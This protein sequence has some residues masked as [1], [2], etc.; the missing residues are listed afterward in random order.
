MLGLAA[1]L[2]ASTCASSEDLAKLHDELTQLSQQF[3]QQQLEVSLLREEDKKI[4][5]NIRC[6]DSQ[7]ADFMTEADHC[8]SGQCPQRNLDRVLGFMATQKHVLIRLRP[9]QTAADMAPL[10]VTQL[11]DMLEP[12]Q[13]TGVSRMLM[14]TM[15]LNMGYE[16]SADLAEKRADAL[17]M[18]M[19][20]A[21][22]LAPSVPRVGPFPVTCQNKSQLLDGYARRFP[23]DRPVAGEP[24]SKE[25]QVAIWIFKV[26]C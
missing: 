8:Q 19:R 22:Q 26:D 23:A 15:Q 9:N 4:W 5:R 13:L 17:L 20:R 10:R 25:P 2:C 12:H 21:L 18:H 16:A 7:V 3:S 1:L 11:R 6:A 24:K 14:L